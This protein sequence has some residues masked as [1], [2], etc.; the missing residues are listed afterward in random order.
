MALLSE[1]AASRLICWV[2][3]GGE[4]QHAPHYGISAAVTDPSSSSQSVAMLARTG[5]CALVLVVDH[6]DAPGE[7]G[8]EHPLRDEARVVGFSSGLARVQAGWL[9]RT[10]ARWVYFEV[11]SN[12]MLDLI[13]MILCLTK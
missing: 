6:R 4:L 1:L 8:L 3:K 5:S 10:L 7:G 11:I 9:G 13:R 2:S 12:A